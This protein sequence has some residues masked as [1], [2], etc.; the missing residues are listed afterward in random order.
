MIIT[1][2][3]I[4][5]K[6]NVIYQRLNDESKP[7]AIKFISIFAVQTNLIKT[8]TVTTVGFNLNLAAEFSKYVDA[9]IRTRLSQNILET[10]KH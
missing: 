6:L 8:D 1:Q 3:Y 2:A 4:T 7:V 10:L 9:Q 5:G